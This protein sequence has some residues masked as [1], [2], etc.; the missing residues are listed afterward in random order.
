MS[1]RAQRCQSH[2]FSTTP[3]ISQSS[4][5]TFPRGYPQKSAC[6]CLVNSQYISHSSYITLP[7]GFR[8]VFSAMIALFIWPNPDIFLGFLYNSRKSLPPKIECICLAKSRCISRS[9]YITSP[10]GFPQKVHVFVWSNP[11]IFLTLP[12]SLF[13]VVSLEVSREFSRQRLH[14]LVWPN[15]G[16]ILGLTIQLPR[17]V[18]HKINA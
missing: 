14:V 18:S 15:P 4:Y 1:F 10:R 9:S 8:R 13:R 3:R 2:Y 5:T 11:N 17:G 7:R 6:N 12:I 16:I